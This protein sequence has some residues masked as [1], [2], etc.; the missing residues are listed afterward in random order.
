MHSIRRTIV[1][2][3]CVLALAACGASASPP[4]T[5][6]PPSSAASGSTGPSPSATASPTPAIA[7]RCDKVAKAFDPK[8]VD[9]TGPWAGDDGGI[10]YLRQAGSVLRWNGMSG[11]D[12]PPA[13]LGREWNNVAQ[14]EITG[15]TVDA[16]WADVPRGQ[17][18]G[19]GTL[20][21]KLEDDG[22]GNI[23]IVKV[24]ETGTGFGNNI[25]TPCAPG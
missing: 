14:G 6:A 13:S 19:N 4:T 15:L 16:D 5:A 23:R 1:L 25:W 11:R 3:C 18:L 7:A 12:G 20:N 10:Y 21:L 9:L 22:T 17:I 8:K 24:S 2:A